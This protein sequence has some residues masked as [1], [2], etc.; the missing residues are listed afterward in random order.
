MH[1]LLAASLVAALLGCGD[2]VGLGP[3]APQPPDASPPPIPDAGVPDAWITPPDAPAQD[4]CQ[5]L[6]REEI[7]HM[8]NYPV[9]FGKAQGLEK[10]P[11]IRQTGLLELT[12]ADISKR[13]V[14]EK[15]PGAVQLGDSRSATPGDDVPDD[16]RRALWARG[17]EIL[18]ETDDS[19]YRENR[20]VTSYTWDRVGSWIRARIREAY[21][22]TF[23][24]SF[25]T[26]A[27]IAVMGDATITAS[28]V[29]GENSS[30]TVYGP[31]QAREFT[32]V[33]S[34]T[35]TR[36]R[37]AA[38]DLWTTIGYQNTIAPFA[39]QARAWVPGADATAAL[40]TPF[41]AMPAAAGIWD[42]HGVSTDVGDALTGFAAATPTTSQ[43][44][45]KLRE[46]SIGFTTGSATANFGAAVI[47]DIAVAVWPL[48]TQGGTRF[49]AAVAV[50]LVNAGVQQISLS[51]QE[52]NAATGAYLGG[53]GA[54]TALADAVNVARSVAVSFV[55]RENVYVAVEQ[56]SGTSRKVTYYTG[57]NT[58]VI[59]ATGI[60]HEFTA[61]VG[62]G[63]VAAGT[64][65]DTLVSAGAE[66]L[67]PAFL[68]QLL[69]GNVAQRSGW[70]LFAPRTG[71][72]VSRAFVGFTGDLTTR[73]TRPP[74]GSVIANNNTITW[75]GPAAVQSEP[76]T[77]LRAI[78]IC[79]LDRS[80]RAN[81][82]AQI[83]GTAVSAH[84][85]Y[86]RAYDG[87]GIF[88]HDWHSLPRI[89]ATA[90]GV[91]GGTTTAG[92]HLV[93]VTFEADDANGLRY[94]SAPG[95]EPATLTSGGAVGN[96]AITVTIE[97]MSHTERT[98]VRAVVWMTEAGRPTYK[99]AAEAAVTGAIQTITINIT[100]ASL[101]DNEVLDQAPVAA[102]DGVVESVPARVTDFVALLVD[103]LAS[104]DPRAGSV[105][106]FTT[107]SRE[108]TGYAAHWYE[109]GA[110]QE[111]LERPITSALEMNG[112]IIIGALDGFSQLTG[113]GPDATNQGSFGVP[114]V[115]LA[116]TGITDHVLTERTPIG[117]VFGSEEGPR[118]LTPGFSVENIDETVERQYSIE[119]GELAGLVY[120]F[121]RE[122]VTFLDSAVQTLRLNTEN[123]RWEADSNRL[124]RDITKRQDGVI[125]LLRDDGKVLRQDDTVFAD[126]ASGYATTIAFRL[127]EP[128]KEGT[129]HGGFVFNG[130][131]VFGEYL[132]THDLSVTV[133]VDF[134]DGTAVFQGTIPAATL[135]A[136]AA[137]GRDYRYVLYTPGIHCYAA[138]CE[139]ELSSTTGETA[140]ID[141][142]DVRY[143]TDGSSDPAQVPEE[144][145]FP[146]TVSAT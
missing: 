115:V 91:A 69:G 52:W 97:P 26:N 139:V 128:S 142:I 38:H 78:A 90:T 131:E 120:D 112:R 7:G 11:D 15:R 33:I 58:G 5:Y 73:S 130:L 81:N 27:D 59:T 108:A 92:D 10:S 80:A 37:L 133:T 96:S 99:R 82:P 71:E 44:D 137:A 13:D 17:D 24:S 12:N 94:R 14:V 104:R 119:G 29:A 117:Y 48:R 75:A 127:R 42:M 136:N 4:V 36:I 125:Y 79:K 30:V 87:T 41:A 122:E 20:A 45:V 43:I 64:P 144:Q 113:D 35:P 47:Q 101:S 9:R 60:V 140:R 111:A 89:T 106:R 103:R 66:P 134:R 123:G 25:V 114:L 74:K 8:A 76:G 86:P 102:G 98:D 83:D 1:R 70:I 95:F 54:I 88:E 32:E 68:E 77:N 146:L 2:N 84:A 19:L 18:L 53:V 61:L 85:G 118:L 121:R 143:S 46:D 141:G 129:A 39:L 138:R 62:Q 109:Q 105:L 40:F 34:A 135:A 31:S 107:P 56:T 67:S 22:G 51:F 65:T 145:R 49:R 93:A 124:G 126:G 72:I 50:S 110:L 100:D 132:G 21:A 116:P 3:D 23:G 57:A 6:P 16:V 63:A 28:Q 55:D